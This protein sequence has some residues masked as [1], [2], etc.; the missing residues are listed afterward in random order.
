MATPLPP[1][2]FPPPTNPLSPLPR[3]PP[4]PSA[5]PPHPMGPRLRVSAEQTSHKGEEPKS[6]KLSEACAIVGVGPQGERVQV[7]PGQPRP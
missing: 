4:P 7:A 5:G 3:W 1:F 6:F 2:S